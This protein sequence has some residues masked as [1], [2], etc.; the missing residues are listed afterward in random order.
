MVILDCYINLIELIKLTN[1]L[2]KLTVPS[3]YDQCL[4]YI[5]KTCFVH[6]FNYF[7]PYTHH[8]HFV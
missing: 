4:L 6:A 2:L 7:S 1:Y 5:S 3:A 8:I